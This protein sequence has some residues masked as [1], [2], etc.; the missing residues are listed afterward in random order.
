VSRK[1]CCST[2]GGVAKRTDASARDLESA[3]GTVNP[4]KPLA[5]AFSLGQGIGA[6][7]SKEMLFACDGRR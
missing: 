3:I 1:S 5:I 6:G 7:M 2:T 4:P